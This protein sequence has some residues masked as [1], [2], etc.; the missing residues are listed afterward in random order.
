MFS[1]VRPSKNQANFEQKVEK[2]L[3]GWKHIAKGT[4]QHIF[5]LKS[6]FFV[7]FGVPFGVQNCTKNEPLKQKQGFWAS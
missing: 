5:S 3:E 1:R 2:N 6:D 4:L 7:D